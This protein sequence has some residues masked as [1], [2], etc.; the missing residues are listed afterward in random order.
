MYAIWVTMGLF[1]VAGNQTPA[2]I[3][4]D[5]YRLVREYGSESGNTSRHRAFF[6]FDRSVPIGFERGVNHNVEDGILVDRLIE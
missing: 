6:I 5:G 3:Y 4:P 2:W 1:E